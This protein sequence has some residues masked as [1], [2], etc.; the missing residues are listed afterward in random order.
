MQPLSQKKVVVL[1]GSRGVGRAIVQTLNSAG[2]QVLAVARNQ[3][4]LSGLK[5]DEPEVETLA[6]DVT[7]E[8]A[9]QTV[10]ER[11]RPDGLVICVGAKRTGS[12]FS[13]LG[14]PHFREHWDNDGKAAF[15]FCQPPERRPPQ[16]GSDT[17]LM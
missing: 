8:R 6:V 7:E 9:P 12:P 11:M 13:R 10:F 16:A 14:W 4:M 3:D 15:A 5:R 2:A 1:G 17:V